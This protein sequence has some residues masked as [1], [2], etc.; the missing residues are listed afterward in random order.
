MWIRNECK[1]SCNSVCLHF[2]GICR[3]WNKVKCGFFEIILHQSVTIEIL[4]FLKVV[5][6]VRMKFG[7]GTM[8]WEREKVTFFSGSLNYCCVLLLLYD[9]TTIFDLLFHTMCCCNG[10][11]LTKQGTTT[12]MD[13]GRCKR[14]EKW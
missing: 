7:G 9:K 4:Y 8:D 12:L 14:L 1:I 11:I 6:G 3:H 10:P 5:V 2:L 13:V